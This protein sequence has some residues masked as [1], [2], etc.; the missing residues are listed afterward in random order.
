MGYASDVPR[1]RDVL[2]KLYAAVIDAGEAGLRK[3]DLE[4]LIP[5]DDPVIP[6]GFWTNNVKATAEGNRGLGD[7]PGVSATGE[8]GAWVYRPEDVED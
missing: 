3:S 7:L 2:L 8:G 6:S 5:Y 4:D 1:R